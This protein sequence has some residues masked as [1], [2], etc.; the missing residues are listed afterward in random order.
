VAEAGSCRW[1]A[2]CCP[3]TRQPNRSLT[4]STRWRWRKAA[5]SVPGLEVSLRDLLER[6][7]LQLGIS[8]QPLEGGVFTLERG[9]AD[10]GELELGRERRAAVREARR[11]GGQHVGRLKGLMRKAALAQRM[12]ASGESA[13]TIATTLGVSRD[14]IYRALSDETQPA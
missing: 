7:L 8:Q 9:G 11:A 13:S 12:H 4:P 10:G 5:A 6:D 14:T 2:R 3:A 1:V